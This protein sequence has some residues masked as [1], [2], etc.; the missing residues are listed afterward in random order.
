ML[1]VSNRGPFRFSTEPDG[2]FT[3][4]P[5]GGGLSSA[6]RPLLTDPAVD[7]CWIAAAMSADDRAALHAGAAHVPD[8]ELVL[9]DLD[10]DLARMHYDVVSNQVLWFLHHGMFDLAHRPR[11][12][13]H[14]SEAWDAY[15]AV[16]RAFADAVVARA[17]RDDVVLVQD[18]HLTLVPGMVTEDRPDLRVG[19]FTHTP[20]SGPDGMRVLPAAAADALLRSMAAVPC[21]FHTERWARAYTASVRELLGPHVAPRAY[22]ASLGPDPAELTEVGGSAAARSALD[23]LEALIGDRRMILRIDR[24][25]PS[26]N[27]ARGFAAYDR[28]LEAHADWRG[29]V[30]FVALCNPSRESLPEYL[31]Y[32]D[33]VERAAAMVNERWGTADWQPVVLDT[34]DDFAGSIAALTRYD[35]LVVNP[36]RDGLNL[37]AKEGPLCNTRDG[38]LCLSPEAGAFEELADAAVAMHPFD[39]EQGAHALH[40]AL[41][42]PVDERAVT[43]AHL[44]R[45]AAARTPQ[46]WLDD[47]VAAIS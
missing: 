32:R 35:V 2:S 11:F 38:V 30:V 19:F 36:I 39:I 28:M 9:L 43:A 33:E 23:E 27:I 25:E 6:L 1:V 45:L 5:G 31:A 8:L 20:F 44:R 42:M 37:V 46:T 34:R 17:P 13:R 15:V 40:R 47:Q 24:V 16:N 4:H 29:A 26:K 14:F 21:G 10:P 18:Y 7:A 12:D 22:A 41:T 3:A